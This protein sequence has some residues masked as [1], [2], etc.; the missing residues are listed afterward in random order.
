MPD[1][2]LDV[3]L[4]DHMAGSVS[5]GDLARRGAKNNDGPVAQFFAD[6]AREI[7]VDRRTL[8]DIATRVGTQPNP[9]K[10]AGAVAVE[11]LS[12][13]KIDHRFTGSPQLSLLLELELL[14]LGIQGKHALWRTLDALADDRLAGLDFGKLM[15]RADDQLTGLESQRLAA[16][17]GAFAR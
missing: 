14:Y 6:L 2:A 9:L 3:Y 16:A 15:Q 8:E 13:L 10:Q 11:R 1:N 7:E 5:A 17:Q 4:T 12:R